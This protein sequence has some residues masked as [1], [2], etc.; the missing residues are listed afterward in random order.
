[1]TFIADILLMAAALGATFYCFI[2]SRRL[3]RFNDLEQGVGGAISSLST[4][5]TDMTHTLERAQGAASESAHSLGDL[6][7]RAEGVA[8]RLELMVAAMHDLPPS[9]A[10]AGASGKGQH[11]RPNASRDYPD[12]TMPDASPSFISRRGVLAAAE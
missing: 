2:L 10:S 6:T 9:N 7:S 11:A 1:M 3:K 12:E 4:Q 8:G 5:V